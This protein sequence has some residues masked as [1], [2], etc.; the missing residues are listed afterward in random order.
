MCGIAGYAS[1]ASDVSS[2]SD[3]ADAMSAALAKR[4]P[5]QEGRWLGRDALL[6]VR[7]LAV[8]DQAGGRQPMAAVGADDATLAV[9]AYSGEVY[10]CA[11]LR[12]ELSAR[13]HQFV[14]RSDTEVVLRAYQEWGPESASRLRGIFAYAV[15]DAV[16][17]ELVLVRDRLGV[18]PLFWTLTEDGLVFGSEP[19]ALFATG[20]CRPVVDMDGMREILG[21][22]PTPG[23][24]VFR[25][26][27]EVAPG[28][29]VRYGRDGLRH[30]TYWSLPARQHELDP[31]QTAEVVRHMLADTV[32]GELASDVALCSMLSGGL[33][34]STI[35]ALACA[36]RGR[37]RCGPDEEARERLRTFSMEFDYHLANFRPDE[38]HDT[39]DSP[40]AHLMARH[41]GTTHHELLV[42]TKDLAD[43]AAQMAVVRAMDRPVAGLDMYVSLMQLCTAVRQSSTVTLTGDAADELFGGYVWFHDPWYVGA[44]GFPWNGASHNLE[45][46]SGLLDRKLVASL[47]VP[48]YAHQRYV[49]ALAEVPRL[50]TD[51]ATERRQREIG[52]LALTRYLPVVLD[53]KDRMGM[54]RALEGRVPFCDHELVEYVF[55]VPRA[56]KVADGREKSLL[57]AAVADLLPAEVLQRRKSP[58]PTV[59]D[60]AYRAALGESLA[61]IVADPLCQVADL[62]DAERLADVL[63]GPWGGLRMGVTRMS[64]ETVIQLE[65]WIREC[66]VQLRLD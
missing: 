50:D 4:G 59:Q 37:D 45:M 23:R 49:E 48:G 31:A 58:F 17:S 10:N 16:R 25:D 14:S 32:E 65:W 6:M 40:F 52:Y 44:D 1:F 64:I 62:L 66:G 47:D 22:T 13:G 43:P 36:S 26:V 30:G 35:S 61:E 33:D 27:F 60:P 5:D 51:S 53:R 12:A 41:L 2:R 15:W 7:R 8:I 38:V 55:N 54:A 24:S 42:T 19:K 20:L 9:L 39:P 29:I 18:Y 21:F 46:L 34:S 28:Q 63:A 57:R 3:L 56:T 11:R